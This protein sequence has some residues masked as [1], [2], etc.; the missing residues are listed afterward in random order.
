[1]S[2]FEGMNKTRR[3]V[4]LPGRVSAQDGDVHHIGSAELALLYGVPLDQCEIYRPHDE[5]RQKGLIE[6]APRFDGNYKLPAA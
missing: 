4:L 3:Y 5:R 2:S 1:M 6:L